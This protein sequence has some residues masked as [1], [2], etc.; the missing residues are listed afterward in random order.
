MSKP[1]SLSPSVIRSTVRDPA[2]A[3]RCPPGLSTRR[4]SSHTA[5]GGTNT[6]HSAPMNPRP[7]GIASR[8]P[9]THAVMTSAICADVICERPYGG[10]VTIESIEL[11]G[12]VRSTSRHFPC[13]TVTESSW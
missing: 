2:N 1:A 7:V 10:S 9:V 5:G 13:Q 3:S 11:S 12:M 8:S 6:S 4:H